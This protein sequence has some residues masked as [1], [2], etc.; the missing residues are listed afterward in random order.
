MAVPKDEIIVVEDEDGEEVKISLLD[1]ADIVYSY[2]QDL[3]DYDLEPDPDEEEYYF[4]DI[5]LQVV[6]GGWEYHTGDPQYDTDHRG[7]WADGSVPA[8][9]SRKKSISIARDLINSIE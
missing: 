7:L 2:G 6:D 4:G 3:K 8:G 5:R 9:V 1:V